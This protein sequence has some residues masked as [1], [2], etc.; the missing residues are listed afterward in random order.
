MYRM[1]QLTPE[2]RKLREKHGS[3]PQRLQ[4][5]TIVLYRENGINPLRSVLP[6]LAQLPVFLSLYYMLRTDLR[7]DIC[8]GI[9]PPGTRT[10]SPAARQRRRTFSSSRT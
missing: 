3:D 7:H 9:N 4:R 6:A 1:A 10:R 5:E 2:I 8:P